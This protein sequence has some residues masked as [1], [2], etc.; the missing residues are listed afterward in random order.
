MQLSW[1]TMQIF[2]PKLSRRNFLKTSL[3]A[4]GGCMFP[5]TALGAIAQDASSERSLSLYHL[6][7]G[8]NL[9]TVYWSQGKYIHEALADINYIL[10]DHR[11]GEIESI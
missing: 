8:E 5:C 9:R 1:E 11:T 7:T 4:V 3:L 6:H 2:E 10:R